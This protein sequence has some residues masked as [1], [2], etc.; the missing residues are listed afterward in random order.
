MKLIRYLLILFL[1][2]LYSYTNA[3]TPNKPTL[4]LVTVDPESGC[5]IITWLPSVTPPSLDIYIIGLATRP[6]PLE[7]VVLAKVGTVD[8][9][10]TQY[11]NC[12]TNS[13]R[14][15]VGYSVFAQKGSGISSG[16]DTPDS[17]VF[18]VADFDSCAGTITL[19]WNDYN[20]W[21]GSTSE[22]NIYRR[23]AP[24]VYNLV[25]QV[26]GTTLTYVLNNVSGNQTY[27]LFVE[28]VN[29]DGIRKSRSNRADVFTQMSQ[30]PNIA[31]ADYATI[32]PGNS[33]DLSFTL[34]GPPVVAQYNIARSNNPAGPFTQIASFNTSNN[35]I[36][37]T[38]NVPFTSGLYYYRLEGINNCGQAYSVS[39][40]AN[41]IIL[42]GTLAGNN[43]SV[44]W[45]DYE[46]W[47]GDV[48][49]YRIIRTNGRNN[50]VVDTIDLGPTT[51]Y[52]IDNISSLANYANPISSLVCYQVD[53]TENMN[54]YGIQGKSL[55]NRL[56]F[57]LN[58]DIRMPNAFIPND[59]DATNQVF[60][61]VFSFLPEHYDMTI[62]NRLGG[63]IWEGSEPWDGRVNGSFVPEGVYLYYMRVY[64]YS[65]DYTELSGS[66]TVVYR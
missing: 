27:E 20:T 1:L 18:L 48:E 33:I 23:I 8:S 45:N 16:F 21:R 65:T 58:P 50:P 54:I 7:P 30:Q 46:D 64:N 62:Y 19:S 47:L 37:Y 34:I 57:S 31:N 29:N 28:A 51:T 13:F 9:T 44:S 49:R 6:N 25:A 66:V 14:E 41:N 3:Q 61:P 39:N 24:N 4:Y 38:D 36:T 22:F 17:T 53:A 60:E 2:Q 32:S 55:S 43:I 42:N 52:F 35:Y 15:P 63:K 5:D 11:M 26:S 12:G 10:T 40:M 56:C 59:P